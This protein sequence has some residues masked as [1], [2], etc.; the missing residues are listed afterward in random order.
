[1]LPSVATTLTQPLGASAKLLAE[2]VA[3]SNPF[4]CPVSVVEV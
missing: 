4:L 2:G 1:V 3:V